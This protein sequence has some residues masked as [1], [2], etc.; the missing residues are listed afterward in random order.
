MWTSEDEDNG[1]EVGQPVRLVENVRRLRRA[2]EMREQ[3]L[4]IWK[5]PYWYVGVYDHHTY[6]R[7]QIAT[8]TE[9]VRWWNV[10]F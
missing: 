5:S 8:C 9:V 6:Y 10:F 2:N 3:L 1:F 7:V 4:K